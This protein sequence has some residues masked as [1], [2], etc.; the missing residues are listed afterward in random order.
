[1]SSGEVPVIVWDI[2]AACTRGQH[3]I[4]ALLEG[5]FGE[6]IPALSWRDPLRMQLLTAWATLGPLRISLCLACGSWQTL[7][8]G[9]R[10]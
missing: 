4:D 6:L 3:P 2:E 9:R 7:R 1:M 10:A 5:G 8:V